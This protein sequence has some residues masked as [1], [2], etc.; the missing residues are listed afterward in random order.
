MDNGALN[1]HGFRRKL[2]ALAMAIIFAA[3]AVT[4]FGFGHFFFL[5]RC[6]HENADGNYGPNFITVNG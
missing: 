6:H 2:K 3:S 5:L 4:A 1:E